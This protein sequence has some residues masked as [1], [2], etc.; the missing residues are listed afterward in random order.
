MIVGIDEVGRGPIAGPLTVCCVV[1]KKKI[2][3]GF[4]KGIKDSKKLTES[5]REIWVE[6]A[7][8]LEKKQVISFTITSVRP[9]TIDTHGMRF[10]L[11]SAVSRGLLKL[12]PLSKD[13]QVLLDGSLFAPKRYRQKTIIKGDEKE[14]LIALASILAKVHRD[15]YMKKMGKRFTKYGFEQHKGYGTKNHYEAIK[16]CGTSPL[17]RYTFLSK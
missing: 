16:K 9:H 3:R 12:S 13:T 1:A 11:R 15:T 8:V 10:A 6:K 5:E 7:H 17:H 2:R 14:P 4:L